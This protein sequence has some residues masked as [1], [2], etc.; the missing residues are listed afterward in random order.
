MAEI[1]ALYEM[2]ELPQSAGAGEA[3]IRKLLYAKV[4]STRLH[5]PAYQPHAH[6]PAPHPPFAGEH[7]HRAPDLVDR[8]RLRVRRIVRVGV[9]EGHHAERLASHGGRRTYHGRDVRGLV[10]RGDQASRARRH[11]CGSIAISALKALPCSLRSP[12]GP[13]T[14]SKCDSTTTALALDPVPTYC[15]K[16]NWMGAG[17]W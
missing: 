2:A 11:M 6:T 3:D 7:A 8:R 9:A 1:T 16:N 5:F 14:H 13:H 15:L 17:D 10:G 12:F 4:T